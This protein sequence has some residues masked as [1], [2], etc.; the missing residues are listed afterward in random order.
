LVA[1][2]TPSFPNVLEHWHYRPS[3]IFVNNKKG[4]KRFVSFW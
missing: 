4:L 1:K 2:I 3:V